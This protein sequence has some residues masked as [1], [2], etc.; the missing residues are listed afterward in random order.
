MGKVRRLDEATGAN[1]FTNPISFTPWMRVKLTLGLVLLVP[2]RLVVSFVFIPLVLV[3]VKA[4]SAG[5]KPGQH[6]QPWQQK[7]NTKV[8]PA[9]ARAWLFLG[10]GYYS[11]A[12]RGRRASVADAPINVITP[13]THLLETLFAIAAYIGAP[14][15]RKE[16]IHM[17]FVGSIFRAAEPILVDRSTSMGTVQ[18]LKDRIRSPGRWSH[19]MVYPEGTTANGRQVIGYKTGAFVPGV[20][21]Q[22]VL[23]R[24][25]LPELGVWT[26]FGRNALETLLLTMST[27]HNHVIVEYLP[28]YVPS[29]EEKADPVLYSLNVKRKVAEAL[30][31]PTTE[32]TLEDLRLLWQAVEAGL[33][34]DAA[35]VEY[36]LV[37]RTFNVRLPELQAVLERFVSINASKSGRVSRQEFSDHLQWP[38]VEHTERLFAEYDTSPCSDDTSAHSSDT[39]A[40]SGGSDDSLQRR[41]L[42]Y[43]E[44]VVGTFDLAMTVPEPD[45]L[46]ALAF[47]AL[48]AGQAQ[49][50]AV[51]MLACLRDRGYDDVVTETRAASFLYRMSQSEDVT[52]SGFA[53]YAHANPDLLVYLSWLIRGEDSI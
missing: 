18:A 29:D 22:P 47:D 25:R 13:H 7:L 23:L 20:P 44:Y 14:L 46:V 8:M 9:V 39:S 1:P 6:L 21:V 51:S 48:S 5:W 27:W 45:E 42:R 15:S 16:N 43:R 34:V 52:A 35:L 38:V 41:G 11:M 28:V 10:F 17:P 33:P 31:L 32:H 30:G 26:N 40:H 36:N 50:S 19:I 4:I 3:L 2:L 12:V 37:S 24:Y 53:S 49:I